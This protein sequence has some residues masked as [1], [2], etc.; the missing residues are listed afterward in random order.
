MG[1]SQFYPKLPSEAKYQSVSIIRHLKEI[2]AVLVLTSTLK[3]L[4]LP[5][6]GGLVVQWSLAG[7]ATISSGSRCDGL[8]LVP[9]DAGTHRTH[10]SCADIERD[11]LLPT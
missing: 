7:R 5:N 11:S 3:Y 9:L 4:I 6:E 1:I 2:W 10:T 8:Q